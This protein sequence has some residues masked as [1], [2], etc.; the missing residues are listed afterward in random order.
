MGATQ[1]LSKQSHPS[2]FLF[3]FFFFAS[4]GFCCPTGIKPCSLYLIK[5]FLLVPPQPW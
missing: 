1:R 2:L 4:G 3:L 5:P